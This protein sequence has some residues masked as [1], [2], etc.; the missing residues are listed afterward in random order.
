MNNDAT[1]N[2]SSDL[3]DMSPVSTPSS[4]SPAPQTTPATSGSSASGSTQAPSSAP[5]R[6]PRK[7]TLTQQQ[8]NQK[9]QRATQDQLVTLELE[10][11]KNPTP[12]AATRERIAQEINMTERSV[13]IWFQN[14]RR[15]AK[16]KMLAKKGLDNGEDCDMPESLRQLLAMQAM[17]SGRPFPR[18]LLGRPGG[19]M[20]Q[21]G[22]GGMLMNGDLTGQGKTVIQ[23]LTCR[24][25]SIG[26]WRRVGQNAM[27]LV[28]FYSPDKACITYYINNDSAGYKIEYPFAYIKS[29][30]LEPGD[31]APNANGSPPRLGGLVIEL[32]RPPNFHMDSSGSGGFYQ[33]GDFTEDQQASQVLTHHLGGHPK[34]LSGQLAKLVSLE[35]FQNRHNPFDMAAMPASAPVSPTLGI[36]R[37]ASQPSV[38]FARPHHPPHVGMF[39]EQYGVHPHLHPSRMHPGHKRQRSRS[40]PIALDFSMLHGPMPTFHVQQPSPQLMHDNHNPFQ[41]LPQQAVQTP[42]GPTLQIDTSAGY[43]MDFRQMPMSATATSPS[44]FASPGF[45]PSNPAQAPMSSSEFGTPQQ[46]NVPFLSPS[47]MVDPHMMPTS[48]SPLSHMSHV[49]PVIAD[50]SPPLSGM[51]RSA[52][53]DMFSMGHE[54]NGMM[55]ETLMLGEMYSKQNLNMPMPSPGYD[56]NGLAMMTDM[57]EFHTPREHMDMPMTPFGT[58]DPNSLQGSLH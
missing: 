21:Y 41:S 22:S 25:L 42:I 40:V 47:P 29:I 49:D 27:D 37:P 3:N 46:F 33:C 20:A 50:H 8:K 15:R 51:H 24:S 57:S 56:E 53:A 36:V 18:Q 44:E 45:Y 4:P 58:I 32:T 7:S 55:D 19:P 39:Q 35:S 12:T 6:P 54:H 9:R 31:T 26:T 48:M 28:I 11:S 17:E 38:Q 16:I 34:V 30:Q 23:H 2:M 5:R 13:Q 1:D 52:S 10:F 14:S 43:G